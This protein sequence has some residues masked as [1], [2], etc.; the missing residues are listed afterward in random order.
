MTTKTR[1]NPAR[2]HSNHAPA[3]TPS[4]PTMPSGDNE[5]A[6]ALRP[7][8]CDPPTRCDHGLACAVLP[9]AQKEIGVDATS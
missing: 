8:I 7:R 6:R 5:N 1:L 4:A 2:P 9:E 3:V